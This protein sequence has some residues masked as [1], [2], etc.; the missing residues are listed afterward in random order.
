MKMR[1]MGLSKIISVLVLMALTVSLLQPALAVASSDANP[2]DNGN[3]QGLPA[4]PEAAESLVVSLNNT[5][6]IVKDMLTRYGVPEESLAWKLLGEAEELL[7]NA[8]QALNTGDYAGAFRLSLQ[9]LGKARAAAHIAV[10]AIFK[11]QV[12]VTIGKL[13][14]LRAEINAEIRAVNATLRLLDR[15]V[16]EGLVNET[17]AVSLRETLEGDITTLLDLKVQVE[18]AIAG[19]T[20]IN[21]TL[22]ENTLKNVELDLKNARKTIGDAVS[23]RV[24]DRVRERIVERIKVMNNTIQ[25]LLEI[26]DEAEAKN[27]TRVAEKLREQATRLER[28]MNRLQER[29]NATLA[30]PHPGIHVLKSLLREKDLLRVLGAKAKLHDTLAVELRERVMED[31][32]RVRACVMNIERLCIRLRMESTILPQD[33]REIVDQMLRVIGDLKNN[34]T[35]MV[36]SLMERNKNMTVEAARNLKQ[37][38]DELKTLAKQ[39]EEKGGGRGRL[40][41]VLVVIE[42]CCDRIDESLNRLE[43]T[44]KV[45]IRLHS[46]G[47]NQT[48]RTQVIV[49]L[50]H[51]S[52]ACI[53]GVAEKAISKEDAK[54]LYEARKD[55]TEAIKNAL[56]GDLD[57][58]LEKIEAAENLCTQVKQSIAEKP[59][60]ES[61]VEELDIVLQILQDLKAGLE[62]GE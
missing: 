35:V 56:K 45:A 59:G 42:K 6:I 13:I 58:A 41:P 16:G 33:Q 62:Q 51:L 7:A 22:I 36:S 47:E 57:K 2:G 39:L 12:N 61:L 18:Q 9:G 30:E 23:E 19:Q 50:K 11:P 43:K 3:V 55:L 52:T 38:A 46:E 15:A 5:I 44:V 26:A 10:A 48:I 27:L 25:R 28:E 8:T 31:L 37:C 20:S 29:L 34:Y 60:A 49:A 53:R 32:A 14:K 40:R 1:S 17:V 54:K 24:M 21:M 4:S